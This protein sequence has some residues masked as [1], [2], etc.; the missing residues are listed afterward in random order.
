MLMVEA[1]FS[2]T[3]SLKKVSTNK[4]NIDKH[5]K[6]Q[7]G[8]PNRK[9]FWAPILSF[10]TVRRCRN[11]LATLLSSSAWSKMSD[12]PLKF[13]SYLSQFQTCK[14]FRFWRTHRYFRLSI[15]VAVTCRHIFRAL[16]DRK[17]QT[18]GEILM[19]SLIV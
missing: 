13:R 11:Q 2:T 8:Y 15:A 10:P 14:Y 19:L 3:V 1:T 16:Y 12:L 7:Y 6:Q 9:Y 18:T 5:R 17:R 4:C